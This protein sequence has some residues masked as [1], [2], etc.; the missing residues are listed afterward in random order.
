MNDQAIILNDEAFKDKIANDGDTYDLD[1]VP[2]EHEAGEEETLMMKVLSQLRK[3]AQMNITPNIPK[4]YVVTMTK[5]S[6]FLHKFWS[7]GGYYKKTK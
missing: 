2:T 1:L 7:E 5:I 4:L 3:K 6:N